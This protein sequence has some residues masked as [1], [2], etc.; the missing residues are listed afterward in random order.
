MIYL[1]LLVFM[2]TACEQPDDTPDKIIKRDVQPMRGKIIAVGNSLSAGYGVTEDAAYPSLLEDE[3]HSRDLYYRVI[4]AGIS[5]ETSSGTLSRIQWVISFKPDIVILETGANDGLRGI[6]PSLT[7]KNIDTILGEL[8]NAGVTVILCGMKMVRNLGDTYV[9]DFEAIYPSLAEQHEVPFMPFF[10][11]GVA[12]EPSLNQSDG[13]H[14]NENG[15]R[16]IVKNL[17]SHVLEVIE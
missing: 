5:G 4:N 3:L 11:K 16:I 2:T 10:L 6:D 12:G 1:L 7:K 13:I 17:L 8:K 14:P 15:Y 9:D